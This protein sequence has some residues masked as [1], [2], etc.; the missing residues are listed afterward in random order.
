VVY[1][2]NTVRGHV[3]VQL[4]SVGAELDGPGKCREG[5]FRE[6]AG[7]AAVSDA[8]H[9]ALRGRHSHY[10]HRRARQAEGTLSR[11]TAALTSGAS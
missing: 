10:I 11:A 7:R 9:A 2:W 8:L 1:D 5:V 6:F 4:D 3:N